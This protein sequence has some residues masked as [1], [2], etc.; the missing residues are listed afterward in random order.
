MPIQKWTKTNT[1]YKEKIKDILFFNYGYYFNNNNLQL[2]ESFSFRNG[3][4]PNHYASVQRSRKACGFPWNLVISA[5]WDGPEE[6]I[7]EE[8]GS[9]E[10]RQAECRTNRRTWH[11]CTCVQWAPTASVVS[12]SMGKPPDVV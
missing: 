12:P 9:E 2:F 6:K 3:F 11:V 5:K 4:P 8:K 10:K 1:K 7:E